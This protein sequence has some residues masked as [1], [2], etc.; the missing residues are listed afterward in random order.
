MILKVIATGLFIGEDTY[1]KSGWNRIDLFLVL[2]SII[3]V[4]I[5]ITSKSNHYLL[6]MVRILRKFRTL[7][8][9][10]RTSGFKQGA[11]TLISSLKPIGNIIFINFTFFII[12]GILGI[13]VRKF[14]CN[15]I[16][17]SCKKQKKIIFQ[18]SYL[19][20]NFIIVLEIILKK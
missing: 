12:F 7:R 8:V 17:I 19:K 16:H 11:T 5:S 10:S 1:L 20:V 18:F 2:V 4:I 6:R 13:H 14:N 3:D 15:F 9:I